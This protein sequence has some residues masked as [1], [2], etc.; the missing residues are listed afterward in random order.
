MKS[1]GF[2]IGLLIIGIQVNAQLIS[3]PDANF[4]R[5]N[6]NSQGQGTTFTFTFQSK[7]HPLLQ[8]RDMTLIPNNGDPPTLPLVPIANSRQVVNNDSTKVSWGFDDSNTNPSNQYTFLIN[9][10]IDINGNGVFNSGSEKPRG[11]GPNGSLPVSYL[12]FKVEKYNESASLEWTTAAEK[13]NA[14]FYVE[15]RAEGESKF[16]TIGYTVSGHAVGNGGGHTYRYIDP[17]IPSGRIFYRLRQVDWDGTT[18]YSEVVTVSNNQ[19]AALK[20]LT[21]PNPSNGNCKL[22]LP[23]GIGNTNI[24][25][26]RVTGEVVSRWNNYSSS[27][28]SFNNLNKGMY[29]L[30]VNVIQTGETLIEKIMVH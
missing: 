17:K 11:C 12:S 9:F 19:S 18:S 23:A 22:S 20:L 10:Y 16:A 8:L 25:L 1:I 4:N 30:L 15:R 5:N 26:K 14:G 21:Y 29:L 24:E 7:I 27:N 28:L 6:G 2:I 3:C 13:E